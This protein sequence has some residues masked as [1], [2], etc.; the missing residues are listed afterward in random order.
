M[1]AACIAFKGQDPIAFYKVS[2]RQPAFGADHILLK[3]GLYLA[4]DGRL[5]KFSLKDAALSLDLSCRAHLLEQIFH[6]VLWL[7]I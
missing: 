6:E 1:S 2:I 7:T 5:S 3:I 4:G